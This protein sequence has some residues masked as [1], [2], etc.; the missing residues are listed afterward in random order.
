M[1]TDR[2]QRLAA[3]LAWIAVALFS[4]G[5][6]GQIA[7]LVT[8]WRGAPISGPL[9]PG[10]DFVVSHR[11][12]N[13]GSAASEPSGV[14]FLVRRLDESKQETH[15]GWRP[16]P[17]L[18][19]GE[20]HAED[21]PLVAPFG[22]P[23]GAY[24]LWALADLEE[25]VEESR[26]G[27]NGAMTDPIGIGYGPDLQ[28]TGIVA[29]ATA[30]QHAPIEIQAEV[31]NEGSDWS[32]ATGLMIL[33]SADESV[34]IHGP[35]PP[36]WHA[37]ELPV[38]ELASGQCVSVEGPV[39]PAAPEGVFFVAG[40]VDPWS[41][42]PELL[43]SNNGL[44]AAP[45]GVGAGPDLVVTEL[46][47]PASMPLGGLVSVEVEV[48]NQGT[49]P[50]HPTSLSVHLSDDDVITPAIPDPAGG[51][52][53]LGTLHVPWL[54]V[55]A[56]DRQSAE[57]MA[58]APSEG[59]WTLGAFVDDSDAVL[60]LL[61][62]NNGFAGEL[63]GV[64]HA[65][66]YIIASIETPPSASGPFDAQVEIC[67]QG[68][69]PGGGTVLNLYLSRDAVLDPMPEGEDVE[70]GDLFFSGLALDEC[71]SF[72]VP[73]HPFS[74]HGDGAYWVIGRVDSQDNVVELIESNNET[75]G[76]PIG[77]GYGPD[78]FVSALAGPDGVRPWYPFDAQ[79][80]VCNQ[81]T[82]PSPPF[83]VG[84][85][86]STDT[87]IEGIGGEPGGPSEPDF[88]LGERPAPPLEPGACSTLAVVLDAAVPG[89]GAY[90][91]GA[92]ADDSGSVRELIETNNARAGSWLGIGHGPNLR[93]ESI[94]A[95]PSALDGAS[96]SIE[97]EVCNVG[98][99]PSPP[100]SLS[101]YLSDDAEIEGF[102]DGGPK[103]DFLLAEVHVPSLFEGECQ[104]SSAMAWLPG[105]AFGLFHVGGIVD[106]WDA[107]PEL[108]ESDNARVLDRLGVGS[109]ADFVVNR[110]SGPTSAF[111]HGV[112]PVEVEVCNQ[113]TLHGGPVELSLYLSEDAEIEGSYFV[114][115]E[116]PMVGFLPVP[117][118]APGACH[119][120][121]V[122]AHAGVP[123]DG[124][125]QLGG[126]V[127]EGQHHPEL[128]EDNNLAVG[129]VVGIGVAP[130]LVIRSLD[131]PLSVPFGGPFG[132]SA[133]VCN[134][135]TAPAPPS[136]LTLYHSEDA[137]VSGHFDGVGSPDVFLD[138]LP[139]APLHPGACTLLMPV[140]FSPVPFAG[141]WHL[142]GIIDEE[143]FVPELIEGNNERVAPA[144][145]V[146]P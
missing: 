31:C 22:L 96:A 113:G 84:F 118:L 144:H 127:D 72:P 35:E 47:G 12:C 15:I 66:D 42:V 90:V 57:V 145:E 100:T 37:G 101:L 89:D 6:P 24:R 27:N 128:R 61:E 124:P 28:V 108:L 115:G 67:N 138:V 88:P 126:I 119:V 104:A 29:P 134:D 50:S 45:I 133:E 5:C 111:P 78:L 52:P 19:A 112:L 36:D 76:D 129:G 54:E 103:S 11:V 3:G 32:H 48:C 14:T 16:L 86:L 141:T 20:C 87:E 91:L 26:R 97:H 10:Q 49:R 135:G 41:L 80:T 75:R 79:V 122:D 74:P 4:S 59:A 83:G 21:T 85:Y 40:L 109:G 73:S 46:R 142:G 2:A 130:D 123:L 132:I 23:D 95:P 136:T 53:L 63:T 143:N 34:D 110:L 102:V 137:D 121:T 62:G 17:P 60:E 116:D 18:A 120:E 98:T 58:H 131:V 94:E 146:L 39:H 64:G 33:L 77:V 30:E 140:L 69:Q 114:P 25:Q 70:L 68:T 38:G 65:P 106:E 44:I 125:W 71:L 117:G 92:I 1:P 99:E 139:V 105:G 7:D 43:E 13:R 93:I 55:G 81:G 56:C 107:V 9:A 51:D 82:E 8:E